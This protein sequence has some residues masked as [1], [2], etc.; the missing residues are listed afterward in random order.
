MVI[1]RGNDILAIVVKGIQWREGVNFLTDSS[2]SL[3][4]G[5]LCHEAGKIISPHTHNHKAVGT[6]AP[7]EVLY[8]ESGIVSCRIYDTHGDCASVVTLEKGDILIQ[9]GGGHAFEVLERARIIEVKQGPYTSRE[10][11]KKA[12]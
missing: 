11:D 6:V 10:D 12:I 7:M 8:I 3:Q 4:V 9:V 5:V 2:K 1:N